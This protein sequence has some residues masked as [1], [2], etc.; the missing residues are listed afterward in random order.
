MAQRLWCRGV[1][2]AKPA[3]AAAAA[4]EE[5]DVAAVEVVCP[6]SSQKSQQ[7]AGAGGNHRSTSRL[8]AFRSLSMLLMPDTPSRGLPACLV[9]A[10]LASILLLG[11]AAYAV[12]TILKFTPIYAPVE[13]LSSAP[14]LSAFTK[15]GNFLLATG[16]ARTK[17]RHTNPYTI[18]VASSALGRVLAA[19]SA[20]TALELGT[21]MARLSALPAAAKGEVAEGELLADV[22][23]NISMADAMTLSGL[24]NV[25][26]VAEIPEESYLTLSFL[27]I[28]LRSSLTHTSFCGYVLQIGGEKLHGP[29]NCASMRGS[30][31]VPPID[32]KGEFWYKVFMQVDQLS[33]ASLRLRA[34]LG[35]LACVSAVVGLAVLL[36][37]SLCYR[38]C[39]CIRGA[40]KGESSPA[41]KAT[42]NAYSP[43]SAG[44]G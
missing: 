39:Y 17:C 11:L 42:A 35:S 10:F 27:G 23:L 13:C 19:T 20:S 32:S 12:A 40:P 26:L 1:S 31:V 16:V 4:E 38:C 43:D 3:G 36:R 29:S 37:A 33:A 44:K 9:G 21:V 41:A 8:L 18:D 7:A 6:E 34:G 14:D 15:E 22:S 5:N 30:L 25:T 28:A 24:G 2:I